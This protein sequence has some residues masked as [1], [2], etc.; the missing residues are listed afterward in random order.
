MSEGLCGN[1]PWCVFGIKKKQKKKSEAY[2]PPQSSLSLA[3]AHSYSAIPIAS[4]YFSSLWCQTCQT[5]LRGSW[6][7][8]FQRSM[9][10]SIS[11]KPSSSPWAQ[12]LLEV[13]RQKKQ[14]Q[15]SMMHGFSIFWCDYR[16]WSR[17][18]PTGS[19]RRQ[20]GRWLLCEGQ[21]Q[22]YGNHYKPFCSQCAFVCIP[23]EPQYNRVQTG[24]SRCESQEVGS[25]KV[26]VLCGLACSSYCI[27]ACIRVL[28]WR[29]SYKSVLTRRDI[30]PIII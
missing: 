13:G 7:Q 18:D 10:H 4:H 8:E 21:N 6:P 11:N 23:T 30:K 16:N 27:R 9:A 2:F 25:A 28:I 5:V 29:G 20:Q 22:I 14:K 19:C 24:L 3:E 26:V 12:V 15:F 17:N 1:G